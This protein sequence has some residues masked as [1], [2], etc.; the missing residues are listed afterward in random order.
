MTESTNITIG[1]SD[2]IEGL[3]LREGQ[4]RP[5]T[6]FGLSPLFWGMAWTHYAL[7]SF[8]TWEQTKPRCCLGTLIL[9]DI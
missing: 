8:K 1:C 4:P 7:F 2:E 9:S 6:V 3:N 5:G